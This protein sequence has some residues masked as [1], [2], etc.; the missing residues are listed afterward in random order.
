[1]VM[2]FSQFIYLYTEYKAK[3]F[4]CDLIPG[5]TNSI[6]VPQPRL[7]FLPAT[8]KNEKYRIKNNT[9]LAQHGRLCHIGSYR[10]NYREL[11]HTV[12]Y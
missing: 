7:S 5:G 1:M 10:L 3:N 2:S 12:A 11:Q 8:R 6:F 9:S 4:S